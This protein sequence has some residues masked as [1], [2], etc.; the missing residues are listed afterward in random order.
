MR[1]LW[2]ILCHDVIISDSGSVAG[3]FNPLSAYIFEGRPDISQTP[4]EIPNSRIHA[5]LML[6]NDSDLQDDFS[7]SVGF[8]PPTG[9]KIASGGNYFHHLLIAPGE[10][11]IFHLTL[12]PLYYEMDGDY[13]VVFNAYGKGGQLDEF[14]TLIHISA[15]D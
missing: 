10:R 6:F 1:I 9:S 5:V 4:Y 3:I 11:K 2:A 13:E 7:V 8:L 14:S 12:A 15:T